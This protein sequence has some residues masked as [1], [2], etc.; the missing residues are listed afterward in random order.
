MSYK[1]WMCERL[2]TP[3]EARC[4]KLPTAGSCERCVLSREGI[5]FC[6]EVSFIMY[7]PLDIEIN[8]GLF[9]YH[10][11]VMTVDIEL[12]NTCWD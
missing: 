3:L 2:M 7:L 12:R 9:I 10:L 1:T 5:F 6:H 11:G 4:A 8:E